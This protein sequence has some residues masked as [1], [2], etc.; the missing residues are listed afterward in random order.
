MCIRDRSIWNELRKFGLIISAFK[1]VNASVIGL[2]IAALYDPIIITSL[3]NYYDF[4]LIL[5]SF[6]IL[7]FIKIPQWAAVIFISFCG[8]IFTLVI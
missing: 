3:K 7:F 5:I 6:I 8:W 1:A 2:L 4:A